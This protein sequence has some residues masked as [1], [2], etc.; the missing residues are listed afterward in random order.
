MRQGQEIGD[1]TTVA[2]MDS[3]G[4]LQ[5]PGLAI[6]VEELNSSHLDDRL[7]RVLDAVHKHLGLLCHRRQ[8]EK[9]SKYSGSDQ[10]LLD[11]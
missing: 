6:L 9:A 8:Q 3:N 11:F 7:F 1:V 10:T 2:V 5:E 4:S